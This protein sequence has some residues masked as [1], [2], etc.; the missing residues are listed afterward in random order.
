MLT[1]NWSG[2]YVWS[3]QAWIV[4]LAMQIHPWPQILG[5]GPATTISNSTTSLQT[6]I[7]ANMRFLLLVT[8]E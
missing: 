3:A 5:G 4:V 8:E 2:S 1:P 6:C 7:T